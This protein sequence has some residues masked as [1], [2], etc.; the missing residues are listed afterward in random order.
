MRETDRLKT[1]SLRQGMP[2][3]F[4]RLVVPVPVPVPVP[5]RLLLVGC[6]PAYGRVYPASH[7]QT[8]R[9]CSGQAGEPPLEA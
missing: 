5:R 3:C 9:L 1:V 4:C 6:W 7:H 8:D 2:W